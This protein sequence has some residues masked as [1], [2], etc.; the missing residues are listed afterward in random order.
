MTIEMTEGSPI[1]PNE[2]QIYG[3]PVFSNNCPL[4]FAM[5]ELTTRNLRRLSHFTFSKSGQVARSS[6]C[7][8][9]HV[10]VSDDDPFQ[11]FYY[12]TL[13][14]RSISWE[15]ILEQNESFRF[16]L[17]TSGEALLQRFQ[18]INACGCGK[19][20]LAITD[21]NMGEKRLNGVQ[22]V[23]LLRKAGFIGSVVLR[24]SEERE[25]L[26]RVHPELTHMLNSEIITSYVEKN[27][28]RKAKDVIQ[29]L[30]KNMRN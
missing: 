29:G 13:F 28:F 7:R 3:V 20:M 17:F 10:L 16:E 15:N 27:N 5:N 11:N 26:T 9:P 18:E 23:R 6:R 19:T 12:E 24:T 2:S 1:V 4:N 21:Y 14:Q 8:C 30:V 22:T 25:D